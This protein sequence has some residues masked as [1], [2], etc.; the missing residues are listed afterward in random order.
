[1]SQKKKRESYEWLCEHLLLMPQYHT[2]AV[3]IVKRFNEEDREVWRQLT[4][5]GNFLAGLALGLAIG[6]SNE[7]NPMMSD[8]DETLPAPGH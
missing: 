3:E 4:D 1:M 7:S 2:E 6:R 8:T 5:R